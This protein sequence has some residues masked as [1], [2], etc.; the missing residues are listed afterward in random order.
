MSTAQAPLPPGPSPAAAVPVLARLRRDVLGTFDELLD[1]YGDVVLLRIAGQRIVIAR[2]AEVG[3][4]ML[5]AAQDRYVK[6]HQYDLFAPMLGQGL[7]TS[8]GSTWRRSRTIV[9][10]MFAKRHLGVYADH[11]AAAA[12]RALD[13]WDREWPDGA[14]IGLDREILHVGLDTV[15]RA[16][17]THDFSDDG[18]AFETAMAG[19]LHE[20]G[21]MSR[22]P[23]ALIGQDLPRVG[24]VRAAR[25]ATPRRW[26]RYLAHG[27]TGAAVIAALV[28]ER[29]RNGHGD[30]DDLL[31]LLMETEDPETG[32]RLSRQ[33]VI[34]EVVTFVAAGHETTAHGLTWMFSCLARSPAARARLDAELAD[35]LGG[36]VPDAAA[37]NELPWLEACFKE[38]MRVYPPVW[39]LPRL[40]T[41]DDELGGYRIPRGTRVLFSVWSTHRD[42]AVYDAPGEFRPERW[43]GDAPST[44]PR[45]AYLPFGGGR[46]ACIGQGFAMLNAMILGAAIAQRYDFA[47]ATSAPIRFEPS[48]TLRPIGGVPMI[49]TRRSDGRPARS[50]GSPPR[51]RA[52]RAPG[53]VT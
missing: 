42:A 24:I 3:R 14:T 16:L 1:Q 52:D 7:V 34:D 22:T 8:S 37:A 4:H 27:E 47:P 53:S 15:G 26:H 36:A 33:Q 44:R 9:Q 46:R 49:A 2:G 51:R 30:R 32:E 50:P 23:A 35:R 5:I 39:H 29:L 45:H 21:H 28:D 17:A 31:R 12:T 40:A 48:I 10:P 20:I 38:A 41:E 43:L 6:S 19:A 11:M 18:Q 25:L 13:T